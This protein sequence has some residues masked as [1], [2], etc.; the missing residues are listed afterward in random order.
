VEKYAGYAKENKKNEAASKLD[1][2]APMAQNL[3]VI[4]NK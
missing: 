4:G 3:R 2:G 1:P